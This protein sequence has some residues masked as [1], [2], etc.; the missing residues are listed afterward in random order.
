MSERASTPTKPALELELTQMNN[1]KSSN[2][3]SNLQGTCKK[4]SGSFGTVII[5]SDLKGASKI[6]PLLSKDGLDHAIFTE[7]IISKHVSNMNCKSLLS[8]NNIQL[9]GNDVKIHMPYYGETLHDWTKTTSYQDKCKNVPR[10]ILQLVDACMALY[11]SDLQHTDIK[12]MNILIDDQNNLTLIDYNIYSLKTLDGWETSVGTWCYVAPEILYRSSPS[13]TSMVWTIG[14]MIA[15]MFSGYPLGSMSR[16]VRNLND[17]Y[18][19]QSTMS[20]ARRRNNNYL[21]LSDKHLSEMTEECKALYKLCTQW[22]AT[23]RPTLDS[24]Y[25]NIIEGQYFNIDLLCLDTISFG[26]QVK[27]H[28]I[29]PARSPYRIKAID[30]ITRFC[31]IKPRLAHILY[32]SIWIFDK[33]G[34]YDM[35]SMAGCISIAHS[36]SGFVIDDTYMNAFNK[37]FNT[38]LY[39]DD[40]EAKMIEISEKLEWNLYDKGA[41]MIAADFGVEPSTILRLLPW[42]MKRV[43]IPYNGLIIAEEVYKATVTQSYNQ[44]KDKDAGDDG[45]KQTDHVSCTT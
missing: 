28:N 5:S 25:K 12:P 3:D 15:E 16:L 23:K 41:D 17:K 18:E 6:E 20:H 7:C 37:M 45:H 24:L 13:D 30:R 31:T 42:V 26:T 44:E 22:D 34:R 8:V 33:Y 10:M 43:Q 32:R 9:V 14:V 36:L 19:W 39:I 38:R 29:I 35:L 11:Q 1:V 2:I 40:V 21:A 27:W 4:R